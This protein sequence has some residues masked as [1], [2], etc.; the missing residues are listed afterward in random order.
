MDRA[1]LNVLNMSI[2][3]GLI[4]AAVIIIR[5][6][7]KKLPHRYSYALW[8]IPAIR[9][10][11][12]ISIS[13]VVSIFNLFK[14][15]VEKNKMEY[16]PSVVHIP[17]EGEI[18]L[19]PFPQVAAGTVSTP[20]VPNVQESGSSVSLAEIA[21]W[22][23]FAGAVIVVLWAVFSYVSVWRRVRISEKEGE[24]FFCANISSPFVFGIIRPRIYLP[25]DL[26]ETDINCIL[27]HEKAHIKRK[28]HLLKLLTVPILALHWFNPLVWLGIRLSTADMELSCDE[29]ALKDYSS[30]SKKD[31]AQA[32]LNISMRQNGLTFSG[33]LGFGES[34]IKMRINGVLRAKKPK[35]WAAAAA[36]IIVAAAAVCL[37]TNAIKT[38]G[39]NDALES[40]G[41]YAGYN[42]D[43]IP[44]LHFDGDDKAEFAKKTEPR[45]LFSKLE[46]GGITTLLLGEGVY[47]TDDEPDLVMAMKL[48]IGISTDG[49]TICSTY[50]V[51]AE[52]LGVSQADYKIGKS[53]SDFRISEYDFELPI[54][55]LD[56]FGGDSDIAAFYAVKN[57]E[58]WIL[59]GD[60]SEVGGESVTVCVDSHSFRMGAAN[61]LVSDEPYPAEYVFNF[62]N[63]KSS[64]YIGP[65]FTA[66]PVKTVGELSDSR[67]MSGLAISLIAENYYN[68]LCPGRYCRAMIDSYDPDGMTVV[69]IYVDNVLV[70]KYGVNSITAV[71]FDQKGNYVNLKEAI[72]DGPVITA[73]AEDYLTFERIFIYD[74]LEYSSDPKDAVEIDGRQYFPVTERGFTVWSRLESF[75]RRIF[76]DE[77]AESRLSDGH[78]CEYRG[79]TYTTGVGEK[80]K[81]TSDEYAAASR[82]DGGNVKMEIYRKLLSQ[83]GEDEYMIT[84]LS[85]I[86]DN[87]TWKI[88]AVEEHNTASGDGYETIYDIDRIK[89]GEEIIP[90]PKEDQLA[91][92]INTFIE[93]YEIY[94]P[95]K[96]KPFTLV[97]PSEGVIDI[98]CGDGSAYI[99]QLSYIN[100][101]WKWVNI[102]EY[103]DNGT[104]GGNSESSENAYASYSVILKSGHIDAGENV[105]GITDGADAI[106]LSVTLPAKWKYD[107]ST[108]SVGGAK[109]FD[110]S[111]P[112]PAKEYDPDIFRSY[113]KGTS[114]PKTF[115]APD[116]ESSQITVFE[117]TEH[118]WTSEEP[119]LIKMRTHADGYYGSSDN[120]SYIVEIGNEWCVYVSFTAYDGF[121][122]ESDNGKKL[123]MEIIKGISVGEYSFR[124]L[125]DG[126]INSLIQGDLELLGILY[127]TRLQVDTG[128]RLTKGKTTYYKVADPKYS[129]FE[130]IMKLMNSVY[131]KS[132]TEKILGGLY[133]QLAVTEN[134]GYTFRREGDLLNI[135]DSFSFTP[136]YTDME[137]RLAV[138]G[139]LD[140]GTRYLF[141]ITDDGWRIDNRWNEPWTESAG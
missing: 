117:E 83:G 45:V 57:G 111:S 86:N 103:E 69:S 41:G 78:Y 110:I 121:D 49:E 54:I 36:I 107:G 53:L 130:E 137:G 63:I 104:A 125:T 22:I 101:R 18:E 44:V 14:P 85:L 84:V 76:S 129:R 70:D 72:N 5:L 29:Y 43:K 89:S 2:T 91:Q 71:G 32:L 123:C 7:L 4:I 34:N 126:E 127:T 38:D 68:S 27:E 133:G 3:G 46:S 62:D 59:M 99:L 24:C 119:Y 77:L 19:I 50:P 58:V 37:L 75:M 109:V 21:G 16:I 102:I 80:A 65:H 122:P 60:T 141:V 9:L 113:P 87:Q 42:Y 81:S 55:E 67:A 61:T 48:K 66:K 132:F 28:D 20:N 131:T 12:P 120:S 98:S 11:C 51:P 140:N 6:M 82:K 93:E 15:E 17:T 52:F 106:K 124:E 135:P 26:P 108:A 33:L 128:A 1:F 31:Y 23:W 74:S 115:I 56:Y 136:D 73:I 114:Y 138:Q 30:Q 13:S 97:S 118:E 116:G 79:K 94:Q 105:W 96:I 88:S 64:D 134:G 40:F 25:K 139:S 90:M 10:L 35:L 112:F 100:D 8:A 95:P 92:I 39:K 47:R